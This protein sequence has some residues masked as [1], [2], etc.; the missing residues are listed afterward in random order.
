MNIIEENKLMNEVSDVLQKINKS[1]DKIK[2]SYFSMSIFEIKHRIK[3]NELNPKKEDKSS[4]LSNV[5][6]MRYGKIGDNFLK[7]ASSEYIKIIENIKKEEKKK[8]KEKRKQLQKIK[9]DNDK[10]IKKDI[11]RSTTSSK[12]KL[13]LIALAI[14]GLSYLLKKTYDKIFTSIHDFN[15]NKILSDFIPKKIIFNQSD[16]TNDDVSSFDLE[17]LS[18]EKVSLTDKH[19]SKNPIEE[20]SKTFDNIF[21]NHIFRDGFGNILNNLNR[22]DS[23]IG[24]LVSKPIELIVN[25]LRKFCKDALTTNKFFNDMGADLFHFVQTVFINPFI[26]IKEILGRNY[27]GRYNSLM[28]RSSDEYTQ[29]MYEIEQ[30]LKNVT[31][32]ETNNELFSFRGHSIK[33]H[34]GFGHDFLNEIQESIEGSNKDFINRVLS[35]T[36]FSG[37]H[38]DEVNRKSI[39]Y[40][41]IDARTNFSSSMRELNFYIDSENAGVMGVGASGGRDLQRLITLG[42]SYFF[43]DENTYNSPTEA[44]EVYRNMIIRNQNFRNITSRLT[45]TI[46]TDIPK[47]LLRARAWHLYNEEFLKPR[48]RM[49]EIANENFDIY[50][51]GSV[52]TD[53]E[54]MIYFNKNISTARKIKLLLDTYFDSSDRNK[55]F[56][57]RYI[58]KMV[59]RSEWA[60]LKSLAITN[61][62][63][64]VVSP[65]HHLN[66]EDY[67]IIKSF[68]NGS[69]VT[70]I[71]QHNNTFGGVGVNYESLLFNLIN[72]YKTKL[73]IEISL[74]EELEKMLEYFKLLYERYLN[75]YKKL[76]KTS[77]GFKIE[78][79]YEVKRRGYQI[80]NDNQYAIDDLIIKFN[81]DKGS[82]VE[83]PDS[84]IEL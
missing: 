50:N 32:N 60:R 79:T 41:S 17:T 70:M 15:V 6:K 22:G 27:V 48:E 57:T 75:N 31:P 33:V 29:A 61:H 56:F 34:V 39:G 10:E 30:T 37:L 55:N 18:E 16:N 65:L 24:Y 9:E 49:L 21:L 1:K 47:L 12:S 71:S 26:S 44:M 63:A 74:Q 14:G 51:S 25:K 20:A 53:M 72:F 64:D 3:S 78:T 23:V 68:S 35:F 28:L 52:E 76:Y 73:N 69:N 19:Y 42:I 36:S 5:E 13:V 82:R 4:T 43:E 62:F 84:P 2:S 40:A 46:K 45:T 59:S 67:G 77:E 58:D 11:K 54:N 7:G 8:F 66:E 81:I 38:M 80:V 83:M